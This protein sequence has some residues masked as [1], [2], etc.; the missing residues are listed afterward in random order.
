VLQLEDG[1]A[2]SD[3]YGF[4]PDPVPM[5]DVE[6]SNWFTATHPRSPFVTGLVVS[7]QLPDGTRISLTDW[8][9]LAL[10]EQTPSAS[11][12]TPVERQDI[13]ALLRERFGL[14]GFVLRPDGLVDVHQG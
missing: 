9:E 4:V 5:V 8:G 13:P 10:T 6:V 2:W 12:V 14:E 1:D 7:I 11:T 3:L